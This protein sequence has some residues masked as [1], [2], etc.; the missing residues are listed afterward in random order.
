MMSV[1]RHPNIVH[2]LGGCTRRATLFIIAELFNKGSLA[3]A[4]LNKN[5]KVISKKKK[6]FCFEIFVF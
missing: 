5:F 4:I 2:S 1:L 3:D 6:V